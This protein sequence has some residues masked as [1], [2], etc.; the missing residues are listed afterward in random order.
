MDS[1]TPILNYVPVS[2]GGPP[3]GGVGT[4]PGFGAFGISQTGHGFVKGNVVRLSGTLYVLASYDSAATAEVLGMV[5]GVINADLFVLTTSGKVSGLV[6]LT[7]GTAYFLGSAGGIT[8]T[9][10]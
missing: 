2:G 10:P 6:G 4:T 7:A 5:S 8:T 9:E 3:A 1:E